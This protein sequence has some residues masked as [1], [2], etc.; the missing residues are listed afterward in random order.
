M[1][2]EFQDALK[3]FH[4]D[5]IE[6]DADEQ[7]GYKTIGALPVVSLICGILS[8]LTF[9]SWG[10]LLVPLVGLVSGGL[11]LRTILNSP[12]DSGGFRLTCAGI[13]LSL[14]FSLLGCTYLVWSY[15]HETPFG[16]FPIT[17]EDIA[18]DPRTGEIPRSARHFAE[19]GQKV[20]IEGYMFAGTHLHDIDQFVLVASDAQNQFE[21]LVREP[22]ESVIVRMIGGSTVSYYSRPVRVGGRLKINE[23]NGS[24][25]PYLLEA[26]VFR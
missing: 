3:G 19:S 24:E 6:H 16:Y 10:M 5:Y 8:I 13:G 9:L 12:E 14:V 1:K 17:F 22:T 2:T 4:R 7:G 25:S 23:K 20:F 26:D 11:A 18:A 21:T 15:Y